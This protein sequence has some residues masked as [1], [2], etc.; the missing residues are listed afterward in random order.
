MPMTGGRKLRK[1]LA[2]EGIQIGRDRLFRLL[3]NNQLL[4]RRRRKHVKT[5]DAYHRFRVYPNRIK[6]LSVQRPNQVFVSD[7][8]YLRTGDDFCYLALV[9]DLFSRKI[10][11]YDVSRS[12]AVEGAQRALMMALEKVTEP[13]KLIHHSDRG[14]QYCCYAYVDMLNTNG[15]KIS[16]TEANHCYENAVAERVNGIL[17]SEFMLGKTLY[18]FKVAKELVKEAITIYNHERLHL[19][20]NYQTPESTYKQAA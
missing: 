17:K 6:D 16:M 20:L 7:I 15:I 19:S 4:L 10:V 2:D 12:L 13:D 1:M 18:S 11:G 14:I 8:T 5:T 9:T 3:R